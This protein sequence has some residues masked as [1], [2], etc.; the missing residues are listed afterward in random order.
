VLPAVASKLVPRPRRFRSCRRR[1]SASVPDTG[2]TGEWVNPDMKEFPG[3]GDEIAYTVVV[4]NEGTV[5]LENVQ[6][7]SPGDAF[8]C[9]DD[10]H[11]PVAVLEVGGSYRCT[12]SRQVGVLVS[13][14]W[15]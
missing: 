4:T 3:A 8:I 13:S 2:Y 6:A 11:Q 7:T 15:R 14:L 9:D 12:E 1:S 5:T 10:V